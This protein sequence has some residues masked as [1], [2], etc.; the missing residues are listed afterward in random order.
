MIYIE[1]KLIAI[2]ALLVLLT[3]GVFIF[4]SLN[5]NKIPRSAKLVFLQK[6]KCSVIG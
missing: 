3:A 6:N 5:D 4:K 2:I 1:R